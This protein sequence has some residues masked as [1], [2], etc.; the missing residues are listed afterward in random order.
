V[1]VLMTLLHDF[2]GA[3]D[4]T[5]YTSKPL[6]PGWLPGYPDYG[7]HTAEDSYQGDINITKATALS[8]NTVFAQ[9]DV[10]LGPDKVRQTAYNM[11]ITTHLDALPAEA[12]GGLRIGVTPLEMADAYATLADNGVHNRATIIS[13]VV[14]P[15]GS[16][17]NLGDPP[18]KRVFT[19]GEAAEGTKVLK[20]VIQNGTGTAADYGCPAAGKTGTTNSLTNAWF[21]GYTPKL[22]TAVWVGYPGGN[23]P[24]ADGFGGALAAPI[25]HDFMSEASDGY[26]DDFPSPSNPFSGNAYFGPHASTGNTNVGTGTNGTSTSGNGSGNQQSIPT[27]STHQPPVSGTGTTGGAL[28][29]PPH[30]HG[31]GHSG[32]TSH[33]GTGTTGSGGGK[34]T[35]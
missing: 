21:V 9:L 14:F 12:I 22:S 28:P 11:G 25:W 13:K 17:V 4:Q 31:G 24:M 19:D 18:S 33:G 30:V 2:D 15:D 16:A 27:P 3:P 8:D 23:I 26:C 29:A 34:K 20:G 35:K 1:F 32:G 6:A 7:V 10:D 5:F